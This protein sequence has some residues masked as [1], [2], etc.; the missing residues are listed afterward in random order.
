MQLKFNLF[1]DMEREDT[2]ND[3][4]DKQC[5]VCEEVFPETEENFY[6]AFS[7]LSKDGT[8]NKHLH[9]KCKACCIKADGIQRILRKYMDTKLLV[10]VN[11][12][13]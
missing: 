4:R 9:N 10:S 3:V 6:I 1:E 5:T 7:Y 13:V 12:V 2:P 8:S 11:A